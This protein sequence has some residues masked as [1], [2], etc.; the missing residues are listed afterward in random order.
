MRRHRIGIA[1]VV[2]LSLGFTACGDDDGGSDPVAGGNEPAITD[3]AGSGDGAGDEP[4]DEPAAPGAEL[5]DPAPPGRAVAEVDGLTLD[6]EPLPTSPCS[7]TADS[8]TFAHANAAGD[9]TIAAGLNR[10]D[11]GWM[12]S[13]AITV[14]E[15]EGEAGPIAYYPAPGPNGVLDASLFAVDG[16]SMAYTGPILKQPANDGSTPPPVDAGTGSVR[17][18]C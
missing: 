7:I 8:I 16:S 6:L 12:G 11:G 13:I 4:A 5:T 9:V 15:P 3:G 18:T 14:F 17:A 10:V 2:A 1:T